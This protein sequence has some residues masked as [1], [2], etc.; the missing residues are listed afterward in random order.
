MLHATETITIYKGGEFLSTVIDTLITDRT[1]GYYNATDL[2]RV[3]TAV[4]YVRDRLAAAG[5]TV[6]VA[7]KTDWQTGDVPTLVS[8]EP[9]L[10]DVSTVRSALA[11]YTSTPAAPAN[12]AGLTAAEANDIERILQDVDDLI[13][14][15]IAA[16]FYSG[17][18]YSGEV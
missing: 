4:A 16:Y 2:N 14:K 17:E 15:M 9:Y 13:T 3:G 8:M 1:G 10:K 7:P 5:I 12:I 11:V 18:I 6:S